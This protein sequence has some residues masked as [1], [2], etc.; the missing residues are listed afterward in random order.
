MDDFLKV[1]L[2]YQIRVRIILFKPLHKFETNNIL[3]ASQYFHQSFL[4]SG[5][6]SSE[7]SSIVMSSSI[8]FWKAQHHGHIS[9]WVSIHF[10]PQVQNADRTDF[11]SERNKYSSLLNKKLVVRRSVISPSIGWNKSTTAYPFLV[12]VSLSEDGCV[13]IVCR[14]ASL[15]SSLFSSNVIYM[16]RAGAVLYSFKPSFCSATLRLRFE[17]CLDHWWILEW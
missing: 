3:A 5:S 11:F 1:H 15:R 14:I 2:L 9:M 17:L 6:F 16:R 7:H 12:A 4:K 8:I 13:I 10:D